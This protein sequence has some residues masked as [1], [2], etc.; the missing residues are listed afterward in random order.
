MSNLSQRQ[1]DAVGCGEV[2]DAYCSV[3]F[4]GEEEG[5]SQQ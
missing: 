5:S 1:R 3:P 2:H 4:T